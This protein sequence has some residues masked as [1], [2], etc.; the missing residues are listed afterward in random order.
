LPVAWIPSLLRELTGGEMSIVVKGE[1]VRE[2]IEDLEQRFPGIRGRLCDG[3][4][5]R[6][7]IS[8]IVDGQV[9]HLKL[10]QPLEG[11]SEVHFVSAIS[12]GGQIP[13]RKS[14]NDG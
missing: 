10:R 6:P 2:V 3:D 5:L 12:G 1:T 13:A 8:I 4:R 7:T 14:D 9:S 11:A